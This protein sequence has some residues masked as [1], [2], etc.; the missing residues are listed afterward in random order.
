MVRKI[1]VEIVM[2]S[3]IIVENVKGTVLIIETKT[4]KEVLAD[5]VLAIQFVVKSPTFAI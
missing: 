2:E 5:L 3:E 4:G 1:A